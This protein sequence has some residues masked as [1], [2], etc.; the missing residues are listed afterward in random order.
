MSELNV[1]AII[2]AKPET[3]DAVRAALQALVVET[4]QQEGCLAYDLFESSSS[5]D[6]FVMVERW[7]SQEALDQ[8]LASPHVAEAL[9]AL[10]GALTGEVAVH[11]LTPVEV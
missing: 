6:T 1:V 11:P 4:R 5:P 3:E 8:H 7:A 2:P 9:G 10:E